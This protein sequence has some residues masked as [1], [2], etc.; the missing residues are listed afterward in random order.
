[1][2]IN[3]QNSSG[4]GNNV[5]SS[6][7]S[8]VARTTSPPVA[9]SPI[10]AGTTTVAPITAPGDGTN[11]AT[12]KTQIDTFMVGSSTYMYMR[13]KTITFTVTGLK[14]N[15][16][17]YPFFNNVY[18]GD[19]C[20]TDNGSQSSD[21]FTNA[22]G[23]VVGNFYL[24]GNLFPCGTHTFKLVDHYI[25]QSRE[26]NGQTV[27]ALVADPLY[28]H[29]EATYEA[30]GILKQLQTQITSTSTIDLVTLQPVNITLSTI[31]AASTPPGIT[32]PSAT[33]CEQWYFEYKIS[34]V[35]TKTFSVSTMT[36]AAPTAPTPNV[37]AGSVNASAITYLNTVVDGRGIYT[38]TFSYRFTTVTTYHQDWI[39]RQADLTG[40]GNTP[41][42]V[43]NSSWRPSGINTADVVEILGTGNKWVRRGV[44]ACPAAL[45]VPVQVR[46]VDPLAQSFLVDSLLSPRGVFITSISVYFKSVDQSTPVVLELRD[47]VNGLPGSTILPGGKVLLPGY[48]AGQSNNATVATTFAFD[49]PIFLQPNKEYCFVLKSS[50]LGYNVWCSRLGDVDVTTGKIIDTQPYLGTLFKSE[51]DSTWIPDSYEDMKF[52]LNVAVFDISKTGNASFRPLLDASTNNYSDLGVVLPLSYM[53]TTLGSKNIIVKIPQ[54][55]L[56]DVGFDKIY[57]DSLATSNNGAPLYFN[58]IPASNLIGEFVINDRIDEDTV[59]IAAN[60]STV[61]TSTGPI[62]V[63]D[64]FG[65]IEVIPSPMPLVTSIGIAEP[66]INTDNNSPITN[67]AVPTFTVGSCTGTV[68]SKT[69]ESVNLFDPRVILVG[70]PVSGTGIAPNAKV[71]SINVDSNILTVDIPHTAGFNGNPV[72]FVST[73]P[74]IRPTPPTIT[75]LTTFTVYTNVLVNE[76]M[77]DYLSTEVEG[78]NINEFVAISEGFSDEGNPLDTTPYSYVTAE[79]VE[80]NGQF[81]QFTQPRL[82]ATPR[83]ENVHQSELGTGNKSLQIDLEFTSTDKNISPIIDTNGMTFT[84]RSYKIDNQSGEINNIFDDPNTG[85]TL[86]KTVLNNLDMNSEIIPGQGL[87]AAKYKG[88]II[89]TTDDYKA[90]SLFVTGNC[91][92]P[93]IFDVYIRTS[94]DVDTH[95]DQNWEW[96]PFKGDYNFNHQNNFPHSINNS[97]V[98]EWLF[99]YSSNAYFNVYD[100]KIVMRSTNNSVI[101][102]IFGLRT[103]A[104]I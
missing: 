99:E 35:T 76:G 2:S 96:M 91:P 70:S 8:V 7:L 40:P 23:D 80:K 69:I 20:S 56:K 94:A 61:A 102:K 95:V 53:S 72:T 63:G 85:G 4:A 48:A 25:E 84:V 74:P 6:Q 26:E 81:H 89:Q 64:T 73:A 34:S 37:G 21:I 59:R 71:V 101:P 16:Q 67:P 79:Q 42:I 58:G 78:T 22:R 3:L 10:P 97:I 60:G 93:A 28:G 32:A 50:S 77:I 65:S 39:G 13:P 90:I 36:A 46:W 19:Y 27:T 44:V 87:A 9:I 55:G 54:H 15:T 31:F 18:V 12:T 43:L 49:Q 88:P 24:P 92:D 17:Y 14:P 57:I 100:I 103:I 66:I 45:Q 52:D 98:N 82:V 29:V 5:G 75:S 86:W 11:N 38:H 51:N 1:M 68:G 104:R 62:I 41:P 33:V 30:S 83:N 47:M